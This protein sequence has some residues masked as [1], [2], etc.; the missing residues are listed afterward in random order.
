MQKASVFIGSSSQ[1]LDAARA[2]EYNLQ[3]D[4]EITV[5]QSGVFMLGKSYLE[6][7]EAALSRFDFALLVV[8]PDDMLFSGDGSRLAPRD[9]VIF[10]LGLFMGR[11]GRNRTFAICSDSER[12]KLPTDFSGIVVEKFQADRTDRN[13][14][15]ATSPACTLVREA[16]RQLGPTESKS[17]S[18]L[19]A[20]TAKVEGVS[21]SVASLV[22]LLARSRA[23]E[24]DIISKQFGRMIATDD[25]QKIAKDLADL[26]TAVRD[27]Q[28]K[29]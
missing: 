23:V 17:L 22:G 15:A 2:I 9:N 5:W 25:L 14:R 12:L 27:Q 24:L 19:Q 29:S 6:S 4:A 1:G 20:A 26:E 18:N 13:L 11:L 10:E 3:A 16:I 28:M 21:E 7:L 8:T